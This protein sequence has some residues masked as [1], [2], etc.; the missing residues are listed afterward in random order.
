MNNTIMRKI[1]V[2]GAYQRL[3]ATPLVA[4]VSISCP[5]TNTGV[6]YFKGDDGSD[7]PWTSGEWHEFVRINLADV[8]IKG[9][10]GDVVTI[11]GGSW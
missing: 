11:V 2:T 10:A 5:P 3:S 6:V 8:Q 9:T 4:S 1:T 7:V